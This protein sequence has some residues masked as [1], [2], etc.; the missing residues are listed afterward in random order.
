ME[1]YNANGERNVLKIRLSK[2]ETE[3]IVFRKYKNA[4]AYTT[5]NYKIKNIKERNK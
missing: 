3:D 4:N 2:E 1:M 5:K